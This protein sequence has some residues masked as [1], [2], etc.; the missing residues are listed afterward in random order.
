MERLETT[1]RVFGMPKGRGLD[2][3][4]VDYAAGAI[5]D[6]AA[7]IVIRSSNIKGDCECELSGAAFED[8]TTYCL[9]AVTSQA[10][11]GWAFDS[12]NIHFW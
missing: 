12:T 10:Y 5:W 3:G 4:D 1:R 9:L 11:R 6:I 7:L 2:G 8:E